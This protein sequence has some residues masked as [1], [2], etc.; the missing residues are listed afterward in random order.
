[1]LPERTWADVACQ[2]FHDE[3]AT[4]T[5]A[6][7]KKRFTLQVTKKNRELGLKWNL[8]SRRFRQLL[9]SSVARIPKSVSSACSELLLGQRV[10]RYWQ[11]RRETGTQNQG[12][13]VRQPGCRKSFHFERSMA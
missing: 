3:L 8:Q 10:T 9:L 5:P 12:S 4:P 2:R 1:M 13:R 7:R 11:T 6:F